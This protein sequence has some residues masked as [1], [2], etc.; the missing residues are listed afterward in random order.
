MTAWPRLRPVGERAFLV[1]F[2]PEVDPAISA[3]VRAA[4]RHLSAH[5]DVAETVPAFRTLL[6]ILADGAD[7]SRFVA[8]V[9]RN[10][11]RFAPASLP[12]GREISVPV[13]Y[14]GR[15]GPDLPEVARRVGLAEDAVIELHRAQTYLVYMVG[16][17]PGFPYLG[18]LPDALRLPRRLSPRTRVPAGSVAI[19]DRLTGIYPQETPG[20]W[21]LIGWTPL[22][23]FD[24]AAERPALCEPGDRMRFASVGEGAAPPASSGKDRPPDL[25]PPHRPVL[26]VREPGLAATVQDGGRRGHRRL[27]VPWSGPMDP[28]G[29]ALANR[30]AGNP[31][32]AAVLE[33]TWPAPVL[34]AV[35]QAV[36]AVAGPGWE[37]AI[38]GWPA[39]PEAPV[40]LR[41]GQVLELRRRGTATWGYVAV[42][43][44]IDVP[45]VLGSRSTFL[46]GGFGGL[47]GRPLRTGD[48]LARGEIADQPR[49]VPGSV[50]VSDDPLVIHVI[51]GPQEA[52]FTGEGFRRVFS[53]VYRVTR[54]VDRT[55]Y[56]LEGPPIPHTGPAE[57]L[58]EGVLPGAIQIPG[59]GQPIVLMA[60]GPT[61][62]GYPKIATVVSADLPHLAQAGPGRRVRFR[63]VTAADLAAPA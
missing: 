52:H 27:G 21:H 57:I 17:A 14:G 59:D 6:I 37:P 23:L 45:P 42:A 51:P 26:A 12:E 39:D 41:R 25:P 48:L 18:V 32:G 53:E 28:G 16:F 5:P 19:A 30:R 44:G 55:G 3:Q 2:A 49:R 62:G 36:C 34:A 22:R 50:P 63:A 47:G 15:R 29:A 7:R 4:D 43:G 1:E 31:E 9:Q 38:D 58:P 40:T 56:R 13:V 54:Q 61:T 8:E 33:V 46:R 10:L 20:G 35:D 60:D 11:E 24:P